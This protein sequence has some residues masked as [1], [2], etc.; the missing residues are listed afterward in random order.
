MNT[1][2]I[3]KYKTKLMSNVDNVLFNMILK[4]NGR[5]RKRG[6]HQKLTKVN[7][8]VIFV[9][10]NGPIGNAYIVFYA[11]SSGYE[12]SYMPTMY[13]AQSS[14]SQKSYNLYHI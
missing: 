9:I 3:T 6:Y 12:K 4:N 2:N 7:H 5:C 8:Q 11:Q 10:S 1:Y 14:S 13:Y